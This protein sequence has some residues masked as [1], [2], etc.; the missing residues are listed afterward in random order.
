MPTVPTLEGRQAFTPDADPS[1]RRSAVN[2]EWVSV[3][4]YGTEHS[5]H[6]RANERWQVMCSANQMDEVC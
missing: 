1:F 5:V 4:V 3:S 6:P 2:R